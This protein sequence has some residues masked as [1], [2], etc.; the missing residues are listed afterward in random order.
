MQIKTIYRF[1]R[2]DG[3]T[4]ITTERPAANYTICYRIIADNGKALTLDGTVLHDVVDTDSTVGWYEVNRP[5]ELDS[6]E[7]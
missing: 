2:E 1:I 5:E 6:P 3:G 4:T 7:A